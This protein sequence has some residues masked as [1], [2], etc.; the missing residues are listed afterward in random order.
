MNRSL[1]RSIHLFSAMTAVTVGITTAAIALGPTMAVA[2]N[3][4]ASN[5]VASSLEG[6]GACGASIPV[7]SIGFVNFHRLGND[8]TLIVHLEHGSPDTTYNVFL[9]GNECSDIDGNLGTVVTNG[10]GVGNGKVEVTVPAGDTEF[11]ADPTTAPNPHTGTS[12][13][14][15]IVTLP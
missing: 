6:N 3:G 8:V 12:N 9:F 2:G 10:A 4:P 13:D 11:F 1:K 14:T 7:P 15:T 5:A